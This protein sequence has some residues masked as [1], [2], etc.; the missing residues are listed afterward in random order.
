MTQTWAWTMGHS[1]TCLDVDGG[2][3]LWPHFTC[4]ERDVVIKKQTQCSISFANG[5]LE[6]DSL[7]SREVFL[8]MFEQLDDTQEYM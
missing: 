5:I 7:W 8:Q 2:A 1:R 3:E 4:W 6:L